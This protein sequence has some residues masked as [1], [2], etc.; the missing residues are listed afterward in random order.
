MA[1]Y[2]YIFQSNHYILTLPPI[3]G[4]VPSHGGLG[5]PQYHRVRGKQPT[6]VQNLPRERDTINVYQPGR[7]KTCKRLPT[8]LETLCNFFSGG[9]GGIK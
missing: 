2:C 4:P 3:D 7:D 1:S 9:G 6:P 5:I 8:G